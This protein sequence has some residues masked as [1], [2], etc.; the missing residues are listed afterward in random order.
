MVLV[1]VPR[2]AIAPHRTLDIR[3]ASR[4]R[5]ALRKV[6]GPRRVVRAVPPIA[7]V[8]NRLLRVE[9][10]AERKRND[11]DAKKGPSIAH[12][13]T[14]RALPGTGVLARRARG[15]IL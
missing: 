12:H 9:S 1:P 8:A 7:Q 6:S 14:P 5:T 3:K 13:R 4:H 2:Q 11:E 10:D 15:F